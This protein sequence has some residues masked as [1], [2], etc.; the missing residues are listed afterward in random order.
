ME[1]RKFNLN[2]FILIFI[3]CLIFFPEKYSD[4]NS[5]IESF[6]V[7]TCTN[8]EPD[9]FGLTEPKNGDKVVVPVT[10]SWENAPFGYSC[11]TSDYNVYEIYLGES[12]TT[13]T[14]VDTQN[15]SL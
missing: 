7:G 10:I 15:A 5:T 6:T 11:D 13:M 14:K 2:S 4:T 1:Q 9:A 3:N 8:V 12:D